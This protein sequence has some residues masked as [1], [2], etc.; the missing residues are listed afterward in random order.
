MQ[1]LHHDEWK[2]QLVGGAQGEPAQ[3]AI[4]GGVS[5]SRDL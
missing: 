5:T 2:G 1:D 4:V 3:D